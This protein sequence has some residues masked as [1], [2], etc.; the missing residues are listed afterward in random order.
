MA[1]AAMGTATA[2]LHEVGAYRA[3]G[4]RS[5]KTVLRGTGKIVL[6]V[7]GDRLSSFEP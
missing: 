5:V 7:P 2:R 6:D 1:T 4:T 3:S